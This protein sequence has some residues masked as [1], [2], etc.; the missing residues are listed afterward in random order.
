[1]WIINFIPLLD[2]GDQEVLLPWWVTALT[3]LLGALGTFWKALSGYF[4]TS[5]KGKQALQLKKVE[6]DHDKLI[7][8]EEVNHSLTEKII[9]LSTL[10]TAMASAL[11]SM[12]DQY[13]KNNPDNA[14]MVEYVKHLIQ[15][16]FKPEKDGMADEK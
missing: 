11:L 7:R 12:I 3:L 8:L 1:M 15:D 4:T 10:N 5:L 6:T 16:T 13:K 14:T 2:A 9:R